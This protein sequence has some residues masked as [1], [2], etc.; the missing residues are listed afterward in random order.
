MPLIFAYAL[1]HTLTGSLATIENK[2]ILGRDPIKMTK[3]YNDNEVLF[4]KNCYK[5]VP[6]EVIPDENVDDIKWIEEM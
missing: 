5:V 2:T 4:A 1:E 3:Y 6:V